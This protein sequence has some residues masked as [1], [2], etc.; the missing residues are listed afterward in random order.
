MYVPVIS[1]IINGVASG[2]KS[3]NDGRV[4]IKEA[5]INSIVKRYEVE[6]VHLAKTLEAETNWDIEAL[7]QSQ[8]SWKDEWFTI[9]LSLPF[10]GAFIPEIQEYVLT[11]F[12]YLNQTPDWYRWAFLGA[13]CASFGLRWWFNKSK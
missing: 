5:K 4:R 6:A 3:W 13:V 8:Y 10:I 1:D 9:L 12:N 11:G 7:R 2:F